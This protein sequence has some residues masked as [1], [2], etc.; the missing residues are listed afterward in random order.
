MAEDKMTTKE[1]EKYL[2]NHLSKR[3]DFLVL[4]T[5]LSWALA[6]EAD[7]FFIN[8]KRQIIEYEIKVSRGD[9]L[10][11]IKKRRNDVSK[12][13]FLIKG[14]HIN[15]FF[16]SKRPSKFY[17]VCPSG[18]ISRNEIP[19]EFGLIQ[20]LSSGQVFTSKQAKKL[21]DNTADDDLVLEVARN[22]CLKQCRL[23]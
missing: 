9:F 21:H 17:Y 8:K 22:F 7:T 3:Q 23:K 11:D 12:Y 10:K 2:L 18:L 19:K 16:Q 14:T 20:V 5:N 13:D 6:F 1:V 4:T 15:D